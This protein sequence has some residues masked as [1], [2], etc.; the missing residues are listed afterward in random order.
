MTVWCSDCNP[1]SSADSPISCS[2]TRKQGPRYVNSFMWSKDSLPAWSRI[3][4][5]LK[6][7]ILIPAASHTALHSCEPI[8]FD[9][10]SEAYSAIKTTMPA[11][12]RG[13]ILTSLADAFTHLKQTQFTAE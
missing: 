3:A 13:A 11:K 12:S 4:L 6:M 5:D 8:Q 7:P 10:K 2:L 1:L 9:C